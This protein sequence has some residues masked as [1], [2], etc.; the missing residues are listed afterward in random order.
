MPE[1]LQMLVS[2]MNQLEVAISCI[3][4]KRSSTTAMN[5]RSRPNGQQKTKATAEHGPIICYKCG[6]AGHF[7][8]GWLTFK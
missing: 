6:Q 4:A 3:D 8:R 5:T 7:T 2:R 1:L